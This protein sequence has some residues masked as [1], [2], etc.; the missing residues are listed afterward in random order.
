[1]C[2]GKGRALCSGGVAVLQGVFPPLL[3]AGGSS[4]AHGRWL[5]I[6]R[7]GCGLS[8]TSRRPAAA[9]CSGPWRGAGGWAPG[10]DALGRL[11][12][13]ALSPAMRCV[14]SR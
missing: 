3:P 1:M 12:T 8:R 14:C 11:G 7:A 6:C 5:S 9:A 10:P 13:A 2:A 4:T